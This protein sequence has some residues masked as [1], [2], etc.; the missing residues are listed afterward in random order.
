MGNW[1][2]VESLAERQLPAF[3]DDEAC[4]KVMMAWANLMAVKMERRG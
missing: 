3:K 1:T 2:G 4:A